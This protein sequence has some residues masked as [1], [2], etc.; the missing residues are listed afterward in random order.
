MYPL[1]F[2]CV[3]GVVVVIPLHFLSVEHLKLQE[4]YG[5]E[6]GTE[7][8]DL[9]GMISGWSF[10]LF[11]IGIWISPQP[12][13]TVPVLQRLSFVVPVVSYSISLFN[14]IISTPFLIIASWLGI[15][16]VKEITL[17]AAETHR[18]KKIV[19]AGVY[20]IVRHPQYIGGL[21]AHVGVSF[22][23]DA[24]YSLLFTPIMIIVVYLISEKEEKELGKEF[25]REYEDY[26]RKVPML[27]PR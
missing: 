1:F 27:I 7:I 4:K 26:K 19:T 15:A 10:F 20:S 16:G 5:N 22:L 3:L 18:T 14:L 17:K 21:L 11:W 2:I 12:T 8:G 23:L 9:F 13:F 6:K 24:W 25:G